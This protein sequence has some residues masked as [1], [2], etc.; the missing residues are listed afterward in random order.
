MKRR[1]LLWVFLFFCCINMAMNVKAEQKLITVEMTQE[2]RY[3]PQ[4]NMPF[5]EQTGEEQLD[6][7]GLSATELQELET[8]LVDA[9][10]K[11]LG[12]VDVSKYKM[13]SDGNCSEY[14]FQI[15]NRHPECFQ[16]ESSLSWMTCGG[17]ITTL[18]INYS[19]DMTEY[20]EI[21]TLVNEAVDEALSYV[22]DDMQEY[23]KALVIHDWLIDHC[24][25]DYGNLQTNTIPESSYN[26]YGA[27]A[28]GV[29]VCDGYS[30]AY[31]YILE[32]KLGI[33]CCRIVSDS[34]N[35][36]WNLIKIGNNY[37]HVDVTWDDPTC[38]T[39]GRVMHNNFLLSDT[40]ISN[41][42]HS[43]WA[44]TQAATDTTYDSTANWKNSSGQIVYHN[45]NWYYTADNQVLKTTDIFDGTTTTVY[46]LGIW[47]SGSGYWIG[48]I[49]R[50]HV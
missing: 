7:A 13:A 40:G 42:N 48:K 19:M 14:Y 37:Y 30:K 47:K 45:G 41:A 26:L 24:Q 32:E 35:H 11:G 9:W 16:V 31:Q 6:N 3:N 4:Y 29:A 33:E 49:V 25:Y 10:E 12:E 43:G 28:Y 15:L 21:Q 1:K 22:S 38:S 8:L 34:M 20:K 2:D 18:R 36:A 17:Y 44:A 50:A 5:F 46:S 23:E 27:L 39:I